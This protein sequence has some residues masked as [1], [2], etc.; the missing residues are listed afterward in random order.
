MGI[1][2]SGRFGGGAAEPGAGITPHFLSYKQRET[3]PP[4]GRGLEGGL[5]KQLAKQAIVD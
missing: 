4:S 3:T 2:I 1:F 5:K